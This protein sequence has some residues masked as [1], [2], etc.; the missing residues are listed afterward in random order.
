[1]ALLTTG[2]GAGVMVSLHVTIV[3][4]PPDTVHSFSSPQVTQCS[5]DC[6]KLFRSAEP[7]P[8]CEDLVTALRERER[9]RER[10]TG[11]AAE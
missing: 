6:S 9:E 4:M 10:L 11:V 7:G 1:M 5:D 3:M 2:V 8:E